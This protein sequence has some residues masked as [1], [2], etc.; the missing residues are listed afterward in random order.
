MPT[1]RFTIQLG[2][3]DLRDVTVATGS[4]EAQSETMSLNIDYTNMARGQVLLLLQEIS[5][6]IHSGPWPPL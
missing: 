1:A 6:R 4:A 5:A 2:R 3:V